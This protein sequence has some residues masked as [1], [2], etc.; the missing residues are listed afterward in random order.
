[1]TDQSTVLSHSTK[2]FPGYDVESKEFNADVHRKHIMGVNVSEYM[3]YLIEEDEDAY[4]K[5]FS[6][7][8]KNGVSPDMVGEPS[9]VFGYLSWMAACP[10]SWSMAG[11]AIWSSLVG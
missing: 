1:V 7:F 3:S 6:R 4:K 9:T 5:Q 2:R 8:I 11:G 10:S